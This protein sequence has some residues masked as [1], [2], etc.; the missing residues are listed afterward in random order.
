M[1][2]NAWLLRNNCTF[3]KNTNFFEFN[4]PEEK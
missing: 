4:D 1:D 3:F 2:T